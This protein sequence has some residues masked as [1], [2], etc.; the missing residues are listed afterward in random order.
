MAEKG[1]NQFLGARSTQKLVKIL[2]GVGVAPL[3]VILPNY[4]DNDGDGRPL[5]APPAYT[6]ILAFSVLK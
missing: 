2:G 4:N 6:R 1:F 5:K 3:R